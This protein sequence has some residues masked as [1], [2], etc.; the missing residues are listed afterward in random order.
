MIKTVLIYWSSTT[1]LYF[2]L[3]TL[4]NGKQL[5][6][7]PTLVTQQ[8]RKP[9]HLLCNTYLP[10]HSYLSPTPI[11][12]S[13]S[14]TQSQNKHLK[15]LIYFIFL[16]LKTK[17]KVTAK[18]YIKTRFILCICANTNFYR[19]YVTLTLFGMAFLIPPLVIFFSSHP[20][21]L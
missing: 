1:Y 19:R 7:P 15:H 13:T 11:I 5:I 4:R 6:V 14:P 9:L 17:P 20:I 3:L 18:F 10:S 2:I 8:N 16:R 21:S 12:P